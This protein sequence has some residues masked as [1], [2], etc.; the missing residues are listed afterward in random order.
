MTINA[1]EPSLLP[2]IPVGTKGFAN[3][4]LFIAS[5]QATD[6]VSFQLLGHGDAS[7][8]NR[9]QVFAQI[10]GVGVPLIDWTTQ[11]TPGLTE[12]TVS[13]P[14]NTLLPFQF[15]SPQNLLHPA[16]N[17]GSNNPNPAGFA[18]INFFLSLDQRFGFNQGTSGLI[19]LSDGGEGPSQCANG[20]CDFQDMV[21]GVR[22]APEPSTLFL[23]GFGLAGLGAAAWR[24]KPR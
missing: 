10:I 9:F 22:V 13:L 24:R 20:D 17:D 6:F 18:D 11:G 8:N 15:I 14:T 16:Q 2:Q 1:T 12:K 4:Y 23:L 3:N 19:G 21:I 7:F 5:S